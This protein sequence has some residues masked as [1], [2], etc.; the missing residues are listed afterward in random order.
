MQRLR[1]QLQD[2]S[3]VECVPAYIYFPRIDSHAYSVCV[4]AYENLAW[5]SSGEL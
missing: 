2:L 1:R 5:I 4:C 3:P